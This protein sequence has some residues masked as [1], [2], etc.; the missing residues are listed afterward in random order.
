MN[1]DDSKLEE[2]SVYGTYMEDAVFFHNGCGHSIYS[3][4]EITLKSMLE[5]VAEHMKECKK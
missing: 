2:W 5:Q 4:Y 1:L 3:E